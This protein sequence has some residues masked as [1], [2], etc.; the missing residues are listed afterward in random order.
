M[1]VGNKTIAVIVFSFGLLLF[2]L[3]E[4]AWA[5]KLKDQF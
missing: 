2:C 1:N 4:I 3:N 5:I